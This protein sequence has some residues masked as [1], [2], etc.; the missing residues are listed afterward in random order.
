MRKI[1]VAFLIAAL[2]VIANQAESADLLGNIDKWV[3]PSVRQ[4]E[5][6]KES[7]MEVIADQKPTKVPLEQPAPTLLVKDQD[8]GLSFPPIGALEMLQEVAHLYQKSQ[9]RV[10]IVDLGCGL[11]YTSALLLLAGGKVDAVEKSLPAAKEANK[12]IYSNT[13]N[14]L[15]YTVA[16]AR[17]YYS[18]IHED[19]V[20]ENQPQWTTR[21]HKIAVC[22]AVLHFLTPDQCDLLARRVFDNLVEGGKAYISA[23]SPYFNALWVKSY[24]NKKSKGRLYPGYSIHSRKIMSATHATADHKP[25]KVKGG[26]VP[27]WSYFGYY[28]GKNAVTDLENSFHIVKNLFMVDDLA[29]IF[30]RAGFKI[31]KCY[32]IDVKGQIVQISDVKVSNHYRSCIVVSK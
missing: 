5:K 6:L 24:L 13:R 16:E 3:D 8:K 12:Y 7:V 28:L 26:R 19:I 1:S 11:G 21:P 25:R 32:Y 22:N 9:E 20:K 4:D 2:T 18:V 17:Q 27:G 30:A 10:A 31:E 23:D 14:I 29:A 15:N